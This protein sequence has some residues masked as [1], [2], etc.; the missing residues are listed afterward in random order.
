VG[1]A[2]GPDGAIYVADTWNQRVQVFSKEGGS[3]RQWPIDG[4][5]AWQSEEKAHLAVEEKPYLAVDTAGCVYV[6][7]PGNYRVLVFDGLGNY[8]LSFGQYGFDER[9]FALPMGIAVDEDGAIYVTDAR[10]GRVLV[11]DPLDVEQC[12][13][14]P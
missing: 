7:D 14:G 4:W 12:T 3:L 6:T 5:D 9:S 13:P 1:I 2:F 10:G 11:F 8:V